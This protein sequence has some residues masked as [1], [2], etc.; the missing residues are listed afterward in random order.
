MLPYLLVGP[1]PPNQLEV[2]LRRRDD[3]RQPVAY[4]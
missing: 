4:L 3:A 1:T 2:V